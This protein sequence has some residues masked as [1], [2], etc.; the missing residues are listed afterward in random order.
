[1]R[2]AGGSLGTHFAA[3]VTSLARLLTMNLHDGTRI[4]LTDHDQDITVAA[5]SI[6]ATGSLSLSATSEG[7]RFA[8]GL[9][10]LGSNASDGETVTVGAKTYTF[11]AT[12]TNVDGNVQIGSDAQESLENLGNA[13]NLGVGSGTAYAASTTVH[14]TALAV[15]PTTASTNGVLIDPNDGTPEGSMS[16]FDADLGSGGVVADLF[17]GETEQFSSRCPGLANDV[18]T[19]W[20]G[21][22]LTG[23][24]RAVHSARVYGSTNRAWWLPNDQRVLNALRIAIRGHNSAVVNPITDGTELGTTGAFINPETDGVAPLKTIPN[25]GSLTATWVHIWAVIQDLTVP[26]D[27]P[28]VYV[29]T[30]IEFLEPNLLP[31]T[32]Q[33]GVEAKTAGF[34]GNV[35][36]TTETLA[37][38]SFGASTLE[39]GS[40]VKYN[41]TDG[42]TV[43]IDS[44]TYTFQDTLTDT[45][46]NVQI[47]ADADE[48]LANLTAAVNLGSGSGTAY[49]ASTT[50]HPTVSAT[51]ESNGDVT[52]TAKTAGAAGS[53]IATTEMLANGS[54][55]AASLSGGEDGKYLADPGFTASAVASSTESGIEGMTVELPTSSAALEHTD[56]RAEL[57]RDAQVTLE[58]VRWDAPDD[59][60]MV[61]FA[62]VFG[63]V[64]N[65]DEG[66]IEF[67]VEGLFTKNRSIR[68]K[69][70]SQQCRHDL[71]DVGCGFDIDGD[72]RTF[73]VSAVVSQ[74]KF[75]T[76]E[77]TQ[78]DDFWNLGVVRFTSG[79]NNGISV[80]VADFD[81]TD[82][83]VTLA[84]PAPLT[85]EVGDTGE[86]WPGCDKTIQTCRNRFDSVVNFGGEPFAPQEGVLYAFKGE[87]P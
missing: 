17:D 65:N 49:A 16:N 45:D 2:T 35:L 23:D 51:Q 34:A 39:D 71:G 38:G 13:I 33:L 28:G 52:L 84:L 54:F 40:D 47:G 18:G 77:L 32:S 62:G 87:A 4:L 57:H 81:Q 9:L 43:T 73:T 12:L 1:M 48:T 56:L 44:K 30:E 60:L 22:D 7:L 76:T 82:N 55:G 19:A 11:Q 36:A 46:G 70:Y 5:R 24:A 3:E 86:I 68:V 53:S 25:S 14:P 37:D 63:D 83:E 15:L 31:G 69:T 79:L 67:E 85:L 21:L 41:A 6:A 26:A 58:Y 27:D 80:E 78:P 8:R 66:N 74:S 72:R 75:E 64:K 59:G 20:A 29:A 10:T 42:E 61:L 50:L